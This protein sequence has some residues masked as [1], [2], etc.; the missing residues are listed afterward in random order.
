MDDLW[1]AS[2]LNNRVARILLR[3]K[4]GYNVEIGTVSFDWTQVVSGE[5]HADLEVKKTHHI[6]CVQFDH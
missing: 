6:P 2:V 5:Y 1:V 3:E 4:V